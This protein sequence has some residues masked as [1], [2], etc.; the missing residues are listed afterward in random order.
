M[1]AASRQSISV[2]LDQIVNISVNTNAIILFIADDFLPINQCIARSCGLK[3]AIA[4]EVNT[5]VTHPHQNNA[6]GIL[7]T[8]LSAPF[9][10][11]LS[12][13][14]VPQRCSHVL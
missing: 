9:S 7:S 1:A 14:A 5:N 4:E 11:R 2:D 12:T 10:G 8:I 13:K 3:V 6:N